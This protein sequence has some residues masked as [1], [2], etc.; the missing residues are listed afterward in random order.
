MNNYVLSCC[1]TADL[2]KEHFQKRNLSY[3]C[4]HYELDGKHYYDDL[5][6]SMPFD[7]FYQADSTHK[8][9]GNGLGLAL[10]EK[11]LTLEKGSVKAEN[12][13][14]AGCRFTVTLRTIK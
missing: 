9:E 13:E 3:I 12:M 1:S 10:V 6:E 14:T 5:G 11:I 8:Q 4:F 7:K 2:T